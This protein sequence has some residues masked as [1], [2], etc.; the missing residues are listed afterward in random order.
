MNYMKTIILGFLSA[1][2]VPVALTGCGSHDAL[3]TIESIEHAGRNQHF[4][5]TRESVD[6]QFTLKNDGDTEATNIAAPNLSNGFSYKGGTFPGSGGTCFTRLPSH[7]SC[8]MVVT[9]DPSNV[10]QRQI[11][12]LS[13]TYFSGN[14]LLATTQN[15]TGIS[16]AQAVLSFTLGGAALMEQGTSDFGSQVVARMRRTLTVN[17]FG[18]KTARD[19]GASQLSN[20]FSYAGGGFPGSGGTCSG[21]LAADSFC[22][23][24]VE[25]D[26]T[27]AEG[28]QSS[29][30]TV[31]YF[32]SLAPQIA[33]CHLSARAAGPAV[34]SIVECPTC[35]A[36][37][38]I[39]FG[40]SGIPRM[41][42]LDVRNDGSTNATSLTASAL[43]SGFSYVGGTFPGTGGNCQAGGT[44]AGGAVCRIA[45]QFDPSGRSGSQRSSVQINYLDSVV[46]RTA[47]Q[48]VTANVMTRALLTWCSGCVDTP[49][50]F[51]E[52]LGT[53]GVGHN[54][55]ID[56]TNIGASAA[57]SITASTLSNGFSYFG[58]V[59]PGTGGTCP[60]AGGTLASGAQCHI[61]V[62]FEPTS[63]IGTH[64]STVTLD[65]FDG[66]ASTTASVEMRITET[67]RSL[68]TINPYTADPYN[69]ST[70]EFDFG[71]GSVGSAIDQQFY[72]YNSGAVAPS[73]FTPEALQASFA[74]KGG[75]FPG[76]GGTCTAAPAPGTSCTVIVRFAPN[77]PGLSA[78]AVSVNYSDSTGSLRA[79]Q[80]I[81]GTGL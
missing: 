36:M 10:S 70:C 13:I 6:H 50:P 27:F 11:T 17:N 15:L 12:T 78:S 43:D 54:F 81:R 42:I 21:V 71:S 48:A 65:Y 52:S 75:A 2:I 74:F 9:F 38:E 73:T 60:A 7:S 37:S 64:A 57:S 72:V 66:T 29:T 68:L 23:L 25:F 61:V 79:T 77:A 67:N 63:I 51:R 4:G 47:I 39:N 45:V 33:I 31:S 30:L 14:K 34:L 56:I 59:Y 55:Y 35:R 1:L 24:V 49:N 32:D 46:A 26:P 22:T 19:I 44:L 16:T 20:G 5:I 69:C 53:W 58:G 18:G 76:T 80:S 62:R 40:L 28:T 41:R 8:K 3:L